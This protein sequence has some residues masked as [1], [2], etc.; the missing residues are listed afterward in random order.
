MSRNIPVDL[1]PVA[2]L[3]DRYAGAYSRGEWIAIASADATFHGAT[4]V[5]W[6]LTEGPSGNDLEAAGFWCNQ[7]NWIA[8]GATP[9]DAL[10]A[11]HARQEAAK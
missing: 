3:E 8:V 9:D 4:R 11:L 6:V 5:G 2:I 7:P 10:N 1:H